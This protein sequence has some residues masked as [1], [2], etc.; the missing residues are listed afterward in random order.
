MARAALAAVADIGGEVAVEHLREFAPDA[1]DELAEL[2]GE[3]IDAA[4]GMGP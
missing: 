1:P 3:A 2:V 4:R